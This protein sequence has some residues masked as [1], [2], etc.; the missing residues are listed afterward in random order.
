[1]RGDVIQSRSRL[2]RHNGE[3]E[4]RRG[5]RAAGQEHGSILDG[6]GA[7]VWVVRSS[8]VTAL[9]SRDLGATRRR[10]NGKEVARG[11]SSWI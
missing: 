5:R 7:Q 1:M 10:R 6:E 2:W 4:R 11:W 9:G 8:G 3:E